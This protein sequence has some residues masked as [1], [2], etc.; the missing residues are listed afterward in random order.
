MNFKYFA[1]GMSCLFAMI[2]V[3]F[4]AT[5]IGA[6]FLEKEQLKSIINPL[7]FAGFAVIGFFLAKKA[8]PNKYVHSSIM[9]L[10]IVAFIALFLDVFKQIPQQLWQ[11]LLASFVLLQIG[12]LIN[13]AL[14][15]LRKNT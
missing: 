13:L 12:I 9:S 11:L 8:V 1:F 10:L 4:I 15:R 7:F 2:I 14:I 5:M 6:Q 3:V